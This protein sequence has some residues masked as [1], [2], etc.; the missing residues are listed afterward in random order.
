MSRPPADSPVAAALALLGQHRERTVR[1]KAT[2]ARHDFFP[3][4]ESVVA[5][6]TEVVEVE[7]KGLTGRALLVNAQFR[8]YVRSL[9][10]AL[11]ALVGPGPNT[12]S[13][14]LAGSLRLVDGEVEGAVAALREEDRRAMDHRF[15]DP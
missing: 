7:H 9:E 10:A 13:F 4:L 15:H 1:V 11:R 8:D 6:P 12:S 3:L 14:R 5:D 2:Q